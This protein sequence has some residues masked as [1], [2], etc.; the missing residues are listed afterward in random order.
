MAILDIKEKEAVEGH[1]HIH[2]WKRDMAVFLK[3]KTKS[4]F[5]GH[6]ILKKVDGS[7]LVVEI[8]TDLSVSILE[9]R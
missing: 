8:V 5:Y 9:S 4:V 6:M 7:C 1:Y 2:I 3:D